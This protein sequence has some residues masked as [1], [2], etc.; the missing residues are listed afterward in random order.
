[1]IYDTY[2]REERAVC[3]HLFRLLHEK[4]ALDPANCVMANL[5]ELLANKE[6]ILNDGNM[7]SKVNVDILRDT[8]IYTEVALIRD[9]Y[10]TRK[11]NVTGF[12]DSLVKLVAIQ[13]EAEFHRLYSEL[14][15][16]LKNPA[17]THPNQIA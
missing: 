13:E 10:H 11:P 2:N 6:I 16:V 12:M 9:A 15:E 3:S 5:L 4:L 14:P 7:L 1:M 8:R 17:K